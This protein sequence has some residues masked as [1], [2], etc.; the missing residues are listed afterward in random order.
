[1]R[2]LVFSDAHGD[3]NGM[4]TAIEDQPAAHTILFLGDGIGAIEHLTRQYPD[5]RFYGVRGN[6]DLASIEQTTRL[7]ELGG[8]R[9]LMT[10][11]HEYNVKFGTQGFIQSAKRNQCHIGVYGHT[12]I[13]EV[14]Y[15]DGLFVM[16]PGSIARRNSHTYGF[17]DITPGGITGNIVHL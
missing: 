9:I 4:M 14:R 6:C 10:H 13:P 8:K 3:I 11:G 16:N 5:R 7:L 15:E 1:M 12:H 17:I 2:I